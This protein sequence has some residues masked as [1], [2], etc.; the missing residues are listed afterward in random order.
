MFEF[1]NEAA[2]F[3]WMV[4]DTAPGGNPGEEPPKTFRG[5]VVWRDDKQSYCY[6]TKDTT[7]TEHEMFELWA[8]LRRVTVDRLNEEHVRPADLTVVDEE[9]LR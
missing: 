8:F 3:E 6:V 2:P 1:N 5:E 4:W 9:K 7:I